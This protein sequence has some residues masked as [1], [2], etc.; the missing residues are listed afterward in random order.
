[1]LLICKR[2][3]VQAAECILQFSERMLTYSDVC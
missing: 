1:M 3:G 2:A